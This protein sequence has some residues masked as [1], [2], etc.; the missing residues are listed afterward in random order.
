MTI[1]TDEWLPTLD[2]VLVAQK[3][4]QPLNVF[5]DVFRSAS[6]LPYGFRA[7]CWYTYARDLA[8]ER[9]GLVVDDP[10]PPTS[11]VA[12]C[13]L[14]SLARGAIYVSVTDHR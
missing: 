7:N 11:K 12:G 9:S 13:F 10:Q 14:R 3:I 6:A 1:I 8:V 4:A 2:H 5:G